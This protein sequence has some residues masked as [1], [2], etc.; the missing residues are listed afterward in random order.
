MGLIRSTLPWLAVCIVTATFAFFALFASSAHAASDLKDAVEAAWRRQPLAQAREARA[1]EFTA[2]QNAA[3]ALLPGPPALHIEHETDQISRNQG[4]RKFNGEIAVP[5]WLPGQQERARTLIGAERG[6]YDGHFAAA[7]LLL[8]GEVRDT[9]WLARAT[10][11]EAQLA[12]AALEGVTALEADVAR[13][14]KAGE[15]ARIDGNRALAEA[16]FQRITLVE[17]QARAQR[18]FEQFRALTGFAQL[19]N[20]DETRVTPQRPALDTHPLVAAAGQSAQA[21]RARVAQAAGDTRDAPE[22]GVGAAQARADAT[23]PW[24]QTVTLRLRIPFGSDNR[25]RPRITAASAELMEAQALQAR[26]AARVEA[27]M[28]AAER[29][30]QAALAALPLAQSRA[31]LARD[32]QQLIARG[33]AAGEFDLPTRLRAEREHKEALLGEARARIEAGRADSRLK[34]AYGLMP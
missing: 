2:R 27:E 3:G 5:L 32:T 33:F 11:A 8:A 6:A 4:L 14:V 31:L 29:E 15:L 10:T 17:A 19:P 24:E 7:R 16:Q 1:E 9:Y 13:R 30:R 20:A 23:R 21:A 34:Q 22:L 12:Q 18:A 25:N 28:A 26:T